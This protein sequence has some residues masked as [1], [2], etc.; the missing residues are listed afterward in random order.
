M[1]NNLTKSKYFE[2]LDKWFTRWGTFHCDR[3]RHKL[4]NFRKMGRHIHPLND[5]KTTVCCQRSRCKHEVHGVLTFQG[6]FP[7]RQRPTKQA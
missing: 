2:F 7:L 6:F 4:P 1:P 3:G 5:S